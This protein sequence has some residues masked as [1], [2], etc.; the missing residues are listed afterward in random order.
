MQIFQFETKSKV[1][2]IRSVWRTVEHNKCD[3]ILITTIYKLTSFWMF[4]IICVALRSN[5]RNTRTE[6]VY[7]NWASLQHRQNQWNQTKALSTKVNDENDKLQVYLNDKQFTGVPLGKIN[8]C[9]IVW[10]CRIIWLALVL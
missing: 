6:L 1:T 3:K 9:R 2:V 10:I 8:L 4:D 5:T 7:K